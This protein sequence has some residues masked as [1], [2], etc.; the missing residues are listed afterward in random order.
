MKKRII[1][2]VRALIC[3]LALAVNL[4]PTAY[5]VGPQVRVSSVTVTP[6]GVCT[7]TVTGENLSNLT[8]LELMLAYDASALTVVETSTASMDIA[9]VDSKTAGFIRYSGISMDGISGTNDL[10]T[11]SFLVAADADFRRLW[12]EQPPGKAEQTRM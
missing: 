8:S 2:R 4:I 1:A 10:L 9:T 5:A 6:G 3:A 12:L 7:V 11:I